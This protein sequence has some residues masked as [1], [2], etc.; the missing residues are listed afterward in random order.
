MTEDLD[1]LDAEL[2]TML[3]FLTP[4]QSKV[5]A[6]HRLTDYGESGL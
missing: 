6:I 3:T 2:L 1:T 5:T 4:N